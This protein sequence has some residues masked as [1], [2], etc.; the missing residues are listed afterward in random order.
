MSGVNK[1]ILVG[2]LGKKP[3]TRTFES[4]Q[5]KATFTMATSEYRK[6]KDGNRIE[7]TEWHNIVCWRNLADTAEQYLD[8]G[9]LIYLEG[10]IRTRT[11]EENGTKK[12]FT[13]IDALT[14]TMLGSKADD[15][16]ATETRVEQPAPP[17]TLPT[18]PESAPEDFSESD[19][20]P[21]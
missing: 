20:L 10:K 18:V 7:Q 12:Y 19:D 16:R 3:D 15:E 9:K 5:K 6:D 13:E 4:G 17:A 8:K 1:V 21:F 2:R 14:F 11:W